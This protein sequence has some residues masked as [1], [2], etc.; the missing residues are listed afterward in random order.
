MPYLVMTTAG[1]AADEPHSI[2]LALVAPDVP[3]IALRVGDNGGIADL[4]PPLI[5]C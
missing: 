4:M 1:P 3:L 2:L 5:P